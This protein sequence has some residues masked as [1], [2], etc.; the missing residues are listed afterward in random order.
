[1]IK[2]FITGGTFD[3]SY[4]YMNGKLFFNKT[5]LPEMLKRSR[6][7]LKVSVETLMM[8]DSLEMNK[9]QTENIISK[10]KSSKSKR[11]V[12]THGTDKMVATA[13]ALAKSNIQDKTI[14]LT[15]AMIPY[16][17]GSSSDGF[18]NLGCA[19]SFV[20]T[21]DAGIYITMQGQYFNWDEVDKNSIKGYFEKKIN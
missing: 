4:D 17:F 20:Q 8:I 19:L 2:I 14:V 7:R 18:F 5:H 21:L 3:K 1:M 11:I 13:R 12:I 15:G 9:S 10:C 6:C 16:A